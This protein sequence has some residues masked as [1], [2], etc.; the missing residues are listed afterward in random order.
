MAPVDNSLM[1]AYQW[2]SHLA[3]A[4]EKASAMAL[5]TFWLIP[6]GGHANADQR[7]RLPGFLLVY[8]SNHSLIIHS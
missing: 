3:N 2:C 1:G 5:L 4:S 6:V 7:V 8:H